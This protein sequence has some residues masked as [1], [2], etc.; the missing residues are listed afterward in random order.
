MNRYQHNKSMLLNTQ[1]N[2]EYYLK[3]D[4]IPL[5]YISKKSEPL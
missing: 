3:T 4:N 1:Q 5:M 2:G